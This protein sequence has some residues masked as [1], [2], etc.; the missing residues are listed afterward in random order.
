VEV[1]GRFKPL[2]QTVYTFEVGSYQSQYALV[3]DPTL[4]YS[5]YLGGSWY[6]LGSGIA[7]DSS[8][9]AYVTGGTESNDF[10]LARPFQATYAGGRDVF[11]TKLNASGGLVYS[12]YLGGSSLDAGWGIAVDS[13]G[14]A[15]VTGWT[16]S[17]DFPLARPFQATYA[18]YFD[19]FVTKLNAS[20]GLVYSTYL[21]GSSGDSGEGIAVDSSG[22]AYVTGWTDSNDFPTA[23]PLQATRTGGGDRRLRHEVKC[24]RQRS[25]L[26]HLPWRQQF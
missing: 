17:N 22:N 2:G 13:S 24:F 3:I 23:R 14:N 11:V 20:G 4:I 26:L 18:G 9:N 6:D 16:E 12:T 21:G 25:R 7:V 10:P 8:G 5:T 19:V 1:A 15:Y